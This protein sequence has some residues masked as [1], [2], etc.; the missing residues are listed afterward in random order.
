MTNGLVTQAAV[1]ALIAA[2]PDVLITQAAIEALGA[3]TANGV[4]SQFGLEVLALGITSG[5]T[6]QFG[7]EVLIPK[8]GGSRT[9]PLLAR[10]VVRS[11]RSAPIAGRFQVT[12]RRTVALT[13]QTSIGRRIVPIT[14]RIVLHGRR[15]VPIVTRLG[16]FGQTRSVP[17]TAKLGFAALP[18]TVVLTAAI[19][20]TLTRLVPLRGWASKTAGGPSAQDVDSAV[21]AESAAVQRLGIARTVPLTARTQRHFFARTVPLTAAPIPFRKAR[22]VALT[23]RIGFTTRFRTVPILTRVLVHRSRLVPLQASL[24]SR[25]RTVPITGR[26]KK[27]G[28]GRTVALTTRTRRTPFRTVPLQGRFKR[29]AAPRTVALRV[30]VTRLVAYRRPSTLLAF[31]ARQTTTFL[32]TTP[33][34]YGDGARITTRLSIAAAVGATEPITLTDA[35]VPAPNFNVAHASTLTETVKAGPSVNEFAV[36]SE[37][38]AIA[39]RPGTTDSVL[40]VDQTMLPIAADSAVLSNGPNFIAFGIADAQTVTDAANVGIGVSDSASEAEQSAAPG[41]L[42]IDSMQYAEVPGLS[43]VAAEPIALTDNPV[44][45]S[46]VEPSDNRW[47]GSERDPQLSVCSTPTCR[48]RCLTQVLAQQCRQRSSPFH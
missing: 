12:S 25:G 39:A 22:T 27:F 41:P 20:R 46:I 5:R 10:F 16:H 28:A 24:R 1:E 6:T 13:A 17:L 35:P 43:M 9:I 26:L 3:W 42:A 4:V 40:M 21:L 30:N 32:L 7:V 19:G 38:A 37:S 15:T 44:I 18:R 11:T 34:G 45:D 33:V 48:P 14:T 47:R 23:G 2:N 8:G 36:A 29:S 31:V